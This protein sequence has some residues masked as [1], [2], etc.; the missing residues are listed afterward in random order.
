[1]GS[2]VLLLVRPRRVPDWATALGGGV[3]L[4][5]VGVLP[6]GDALQQLATSWNVFL[7]F[8]GLG[9][10]AA[11]AD[12]AG[13]FRAAAE[14]AA[15]LGRGSQRR[16]LISLYAAGVLITAVLSNDA[17]ALLLTPVAFAVATRL[18]QSRQCK[19]DG[20]NRRKQKAHK[21]RSKRKWR[22][23]EHQQVGPV[24]DGQQK[25]GRI[26]D[27]RARERVWL[28]MPFAVPSGRSQRFERRAVDEQSVAHDIPGAA[29]ARS[30]RGGNVPAAGARRSRVRAAGGDHRQTDE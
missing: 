30:T 16:L 9:L 7:F 6:V 26:G 15:H 25:R 11:T 24:G 4:V 18:Q 23:R 27:K 29:T 5:L 3:L 12:R 20:E 1:M 19:H 14:A 17:R 8:L 28:A 21:E 13:V 10:S 22:V 2:L